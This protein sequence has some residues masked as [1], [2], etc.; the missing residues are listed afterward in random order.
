MREKRVWYARVANWRFPGS[1]RRDNQRAPGEL[2]LHC[3]L[4]EAGIHGGRVV[5]VVIPADQL[6][7]LLG[8]ASNALRERN[9]ARLGAM[10]ASLAGLPSGKGDG[11]G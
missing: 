11:N 3:E 7:I 1:Y 8:M 9:D 10:R 2:T 5:E 6:E 4:S